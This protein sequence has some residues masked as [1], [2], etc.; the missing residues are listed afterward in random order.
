MA[1]N[2]LSVNIGV[3]LE[4]DEKTA[5]KQLEGVAKKLGMTGEGLLKDLNIE[6]DV[7]NIDAVE[8]KLWS[9]INLTEGL[10]DSLKDIFKADPSAQTRM[11]SEVRKQL[12]L[13]EREAT[14]KVGKAKGK[15]GNIKGIQD[16]I[17]ME[18][19]GEKGVNFNVGSFKGKLYANVKNWI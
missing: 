16:A 9:I 17:S 7:V 15:T 10:G 12:N 13:I 5:I 4:I 2:E 8:Q 14:S 1:D 11:F 6:I 19:F 18:L 3:N